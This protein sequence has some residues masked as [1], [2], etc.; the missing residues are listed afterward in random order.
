MKILELRFKNINSLYGEWCIDFTD[1]D[2]VADGL[3]AITGATGSGKT[4][5]LD[6][7]CLALYG[8]TPRLGKM[9]ASDN[10]VMSRQTGECFAEVLFEAASGTYRTTWHQ[11]RSRK[12][13]GA[14]LQSPKREVAKADGTILAEKLKE[15]QDQI[16][17]ITGM[18]FDRF[19]R[20]ILLAQGSFDTFLKANADERSP[21]LEQI[22]GTEIYS[23]IS[24]AVHQRNSAEN[25]TLS[26]LKAGLG[27]IPLLGE[28]Q[29]EQIRFDLK[30]VEE[31]HTTEAQK[32]DAAKAAL[33]WIIRIETLEKELETNGTEQKAWRIENE[34]FQPEAERLA[35]AKRARPLD[36]DHLKL[37][38]LRNLRSK[39]ET[40]LND[41]NK[42]L[43]ELDEQNKEA[44]NALTVTSQQLEEKTQAQ[45]ELAPILKQ[46]RSLDTTIA[47]RSA[48]LEKE[49]ADLTK[50]QDELGALQAREM[51]NQAKQKQLQTELNEAETYQK[52]HAQDA[53]LV[54]QLAA[55][56][57]SLEQLKT[58][59]ADH[60]KAKTAAEQ[61][62]T[63]VQT[64]AA[65]ALSATENLSLVQQQFIQAETELTT[66]NGDLETMRAGQS[67]SD[68]QS[69]LSELQLRF[70]LEKQVSD[71]RAAFIAK[72]DEVKTTV[73]ELAEKVKE[74]GGL[75]REQ[76][77]LLQN[78]QLR[79]KIESL[80]TERGELIDGRPCPLCG[81]LE[82]PYT[83]DL[84]KPEIG[85]IDKINAALS[86][87]A[88][89][90]NTLTGKQSAA[91]A[92]CQ[93]LQESIEHD[94]AELQTLATGSAEEA[95]E[96]A[97]RIEQLKTLEQ[98]QNKAKAA[99]DTVREALNQQRLDEQTAKQTAHSAEE[100][101]NAAELRKEETTEQFEKA[102]SA[103]FQTLEPYGIE[104]L[105]GAADQLKARRDEWL[106]AEKQQADLKQA[107]AHLQTT[108]ANQSEQL[109]VLK[110][111]HMEQAELLNGKQVALTQLITDRQ[112]QFGERQPDDAER[113]SQTAFET[114]RVANEAAQKKQ[115]QT[116]Q[117]LA[118]AREK[119][120]TLEESKQETEKEL[121]ENEPLFF[122][123]L[124]TA[125]FED[126]AAYL[127]A[128]LSESDQA[129]LE[130]QADELKHRHTR[131]SALEAEKMKQLQAERE[132]KHIE[133]SPEEHGVFVEA[134]IKLQQQIG[135]LK[136]RI[137][138]NEKAKDLHSEKLVE[139]EK[140]QMECTRWNTL[141]E[142]IGSADGKKFRNFAQGL[143]FE[144][145]VSHANRQL[146]KM[147]DRYLLVRDIQQ[148]LDLD[149]VDNY[150]AGEIRPVK[151]L[152]G[153]ESF[154]VSLSLALGLSKMASKHI[155]VDSL[156]LDEGFGT[157]DENALETALE[158]L[159]ELKQDGKLIGVISHVGALKERIGTQINVHTTSGGRSR[160]SG[161]GV[162]KI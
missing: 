15:V 60:A 114:A 71:N 112:T 160:L 63:T 82:H 99:L 27:G 55:I 130:K 106:N 108:L 133:S 148:P 67:V 122:Q 42:A 85:A 152:S 65:K 91:E 34:A 72:T 125:G 110:R 5:I 24:K 105:D 109:D 2:F 161:T 57:Q 104:S 76:S 95:E 6:A 17:Q 151:N 35:I 157:L 88:A 134:C 68:W 162:T 102:Q 86:E 142:L 144:L 131:L 44:T 19:T 38:N 77:L 119:I 46:V 143:T 126:E 21:I 29:L 74:Q 43:P 116:E 53:E 33:D 75:Q 98:K 81:A 48:A 141:H 132:Q 31:Q 107:I 87:L 32:R 137:K 59:E 41:A 66:I 117:S 39:I 62:A 13:A 100:K 56:F 58:L 128:R 7:L 40:G 115:N 139:I 146:A 8:Q 156:F 123:A 4:T 61:A 3:F 158:A 94:D 118:R 140:Q 135:G 92:R 120:Q 96:I 52:A 138:A 9:T 69:R 159:A 12:K 1:P 124:E 121:A 49:E 89:Q 83:T 11:H 129:E 37:V 127:A 22:T 30:Q 18:S 73:S 113:E 149:V 25:Q 16:D 20:S 28:E 26:E 101:H 155:R 50:L 23:E 80:E 84:P 93:T 79:Q 153:G 150:Q 51:E 97:G 147:S 36:L 47:E 64:S 111:R 154:I 45:Q 54:G 136:D 10:E 90:I 103:L 78:L 14:P 145:M 70:K